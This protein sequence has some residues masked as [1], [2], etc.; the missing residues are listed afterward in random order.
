MELKE[1]EILK[2]QV[3]KLDD[4]AFDLESWK[5]Y[6]INLL[7]RIFGRESQ[8]IMQIKELKYDFS[9]WTLRDTSG[10]LDPIKKKAKVIVQSAINELEQFGLP[11]KDKAEEPV[12][13]I[14]EILKDELKG[15]EYKRVVRIMGKDES[16][17]VKSGQLA[18]LIND[19]DMQ[20]K[21]QIITNLIMGNY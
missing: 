18:E 4:K 2:N 7:D 5:I 6:T 13:L 10:S 11:E 15:S 19:L 14:A 12:N 3:T 16:D 21:N 20:T 1:L 17:E 8:K 9:S